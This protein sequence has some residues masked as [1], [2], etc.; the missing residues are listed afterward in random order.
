[1]GTKTVLVV[2]GGLGSLSSAIRLAK[3]GLRVKLFEK[4]PTLGGKMSEYRQGGFRWDTGPSL[5]TMPFVVEEIF[6]SVGQKR[7]DYLNLLEL[8]PLCRYFFNDYTQ[9]DAS[10]DRKKM[11]SALSKFSPSQQQAYLDFMKYA[12]KIFNTAAEIFLFTPIHEIRKLLKTKNIPLLFQLSRIDPFRKVNQAISD[13]FSDQRLVQL[14]NRYATYN[15]SDPFKAPATLNIIPYVENELGGYYI[16]GGM[17]RLVEA[18][19]NLARQL[20]VE[21]FTSSKVDK[22]KQNNNK[23]TGLLVQGEFIPADYVV[24]G[25]DVVETFNTLLDNF[26]NQRDKLNT[27]EPSLSGMVFLWGVNRAFPSLAHHNIIFSSNYQR[28]FSQIFDDHQPPDD[29]TIYIAISS[30]SN[31]A[32]APAASENW[33][34]LLNMPYLHQSQKWNEERVRMKEIV[35]RKLLRYG[36]DISSHIQYEKCMTPYDFYE[37]Y[38]SNRGSI[39]GLSSNSRFTAFRR[40]ANRSRLIKGLY[41]VGGS[42]HPGG[43]I[44]LVLLSGKMVAELIAEKENIPQLVSTSIAEHLQIHLNSIAEIRN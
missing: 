7:S 23:I 34:V 21:I 20:G 16:Q 13:F 29:P 11:L 27:L 43:G 28:E 37:N 9:L 42:T 17:Y 6:K 39:Y 5:M 2:G 15:G 30:K 1:M 10:N 26:K 33:F 14:F 41:F 44:P 8:E 19:E 36:L 22:I 40:P 31:L 3:L 18:L 25:A 24:C 35:L 4:N 38:A 32:D 12:G